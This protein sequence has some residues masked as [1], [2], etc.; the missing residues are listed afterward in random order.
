MRHEGR[1]LK[2]NFLEIQGIIYHYVS[3]FCIS[4]SSGIEHN[5]NTFVMIVYYMLIS[6]A[7]KNQIL[8]VF[9]IRFLLLTEIYQNLTLLKPQ[10]L[11][12]KDFCRLIWTGS[13][14]VIHSLMI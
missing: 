13:V 7:M 11:S 8:D 2:K 9:V 5:V 14:L 12:L 6:A 3:L 1:I 10:L 4:K